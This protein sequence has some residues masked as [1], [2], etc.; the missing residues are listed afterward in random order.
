MPIALEPGKRWPIVLDSDKGMNP[1]PTFYARALSLREQSAVDDVLSGAK[2]KSRKVKDVFAEHFETLKKFLL[3]WD[4]MVDANTGKAVPYDVNELDNIIDF[5][6]AR[7]IL[8]KMLV[9][10]HVTLEEKKD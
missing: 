4:N 10:E 9:N 6:Q 1:E 2:D 3:G 5:V 8:T 7:E